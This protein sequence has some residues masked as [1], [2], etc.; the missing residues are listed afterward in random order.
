MRHLGSRKNLVH[1]VDLTT[2]TTCCRGIATACFIGYPTRPQEGPCMQI[3]PSIP[4]A[5]FL[6]VP[7]MVAGLALGFILFKP[8]LDYIDERNAIS[9]T[10]RRAFLATRS[11][12]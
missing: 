11:A 3:I 12:P 6:T 1:G 7:F 4:E 8:L 5:A 9:G 2:G 10:A